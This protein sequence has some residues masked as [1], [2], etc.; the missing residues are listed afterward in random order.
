MT[1]P[2]CV[3]NLFQLFKFYLKCPDYCRFEAFLAPCLLQKAKT[4]PLT[5]QIQTMGQPSWLLSYVYF[6]LFSFCLL[7]R[8]LATH[9]AYF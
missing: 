5:E 3:H 6:G 2:P 9:V 1:F 7:A 8:E 4:R